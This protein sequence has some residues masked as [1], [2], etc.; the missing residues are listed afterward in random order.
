MKVY[1][2]SAVYRTIEARQLLSLIPLLVRPGVEYSPIIGDAL[3]ERSRSISATTFLRHSDAD[4]HLSIDS[5]IVDFDTDKTMEMCEQAMT[6]DVVGGL[7]VTRSMERT[8]PTSFP[9]QGQKMLLENDPTPV[10]MQYLATGF[11]AV[12]RR[13]FEKLAEDLPL[14]HAKDGTRAFYPFYLPFVADDDEGEPFL[15]SED[16]AFSQRAR[17]AGFG[18]NLNP[19]IRL[20]HASS[21]IY[22]VE[23][24]FNE[25]IPQHALTLERKDGTHWRLESAARQG[26]EKQEPVSVQSRQQRRLQERAKVKASS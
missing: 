26:A 13:V 8:F 10:P 1:I 23:D 21:M 4:I 19:S 20:G 3:I 6:H 7:Y 18:L 22:R 17:D 2:G 24:M 11:M 9:F 12:H 15:L 16:W 25:P 5:D 14:C